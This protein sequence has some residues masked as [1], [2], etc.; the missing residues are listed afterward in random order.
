MRPG[1]YEVDG[2]AALTTAFNH[3]DVLSAHVGRAC[4]SPAP[5]FA[6]ALFLLLNAVLFIR[7]AEVVPQ[8]EGLPIYNVVVLICLIASI[9]EVLA[10]AQP[11]ILARSPITLCVLG[12]MPA[13]ILSRASHGDL[14]GASYYSQEF[15][16][17]VVYYVLLVSL[18]TSPQ[19][20][21]QLLRA[22]VVFILVLT[23]LAV[24]RY[25]DLISLDTVAPWE[26][27]QF[28]ASADDPLVVVVRLVGA[29]IFG[30]P[31][32]MAR[33]VVVGII[34]A[35]FEISLSRGLLARLVWAAVILTFAHALQLTYSRGGL[36]SLMGGLLTLLH[37]RFGTKKGA[38]LLVFAMP[39]LMLFAGRQTDV[40]VSSG[41]G[42][43][44]IQ[45]W[46]DGLVAMRSAPLFGIGTDQYASMAGNHAHNS[47]VEAY[48]ETGFFGGTCFVAAT[49]MAATGLYRLRREPRL[50]ANTE[51]SRLRPT[52]LALMMG[53]IV[54]ELSSS[55]EYS[56][57]TYV[58]L[59]LCCAYQAMAEREAPG[60][61]P[62]LSPTLVARTILISVVTLV[63]LHL[64]TKFNA[65]F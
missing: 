22:M 45:L 11:H 16:K 32:D 34:I 9:P 64:Y 57:L 38:F 26:E 21:R 1:Y 37:Q 20:L 2:D 62:R 7:P 51:L 54:G 39:A 36:L 46:S 30:N 47:F 55:R 10:G 6:F 48:V 56:P 59:G 65:R 35:A 44:R 58:L 43:L 5:R 14:A 63:S 4:S 29:G 17:V 18:V 25:H 15:A 23:T 61:T 50:S 49:C 24:L 52:V 53:W 13:I 41:T 8:L 42:Q 40:G 28:R 27:N 33:L 3:P 31:N 12:M 19:R 60:S